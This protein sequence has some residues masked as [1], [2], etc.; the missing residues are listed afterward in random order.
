MVIKIVPSET[1]PCPEIEIYIALWFLDLWSL[2]PPL[3]L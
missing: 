1:I 3:V 2:T